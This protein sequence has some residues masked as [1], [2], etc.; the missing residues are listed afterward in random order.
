M[1]DILIVI[2]AVVFG[3]IIQKLLTFNWKEEETKPTIPHKLH[4]WVTSQATSQL[5]E[6]YLVCSVC[7]KK[8]GT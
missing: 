1:T 2:A 3:L 7:H 5:G 4:D 6:E 8:A